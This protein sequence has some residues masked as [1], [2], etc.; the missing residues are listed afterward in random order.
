M[1][2]HPSAP[3]RTGSRSLLGYQNLQLLKFLINKGAVQ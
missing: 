3:L 1:E 2:S